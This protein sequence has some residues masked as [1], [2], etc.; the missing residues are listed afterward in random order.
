M[1]EMIERVARA[2]CK[3]I[4][5]RDADDKDGG[6]H[7]LGTWLDPVERW[8]TGYID[9]ARAAIAAMRE[10]TEAMLAAAVQF[11]DHLRAEHPD[12]DDQWHAA[13]WAATKAEQMGLSQ[14]WQDMIDAALPEQPENKRPGTEREGE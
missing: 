11:P 6:P 4:S 12:K 14:R 8:W 7:P 2:M 5:G 13:M 1:S 3:E 10:P 9:A